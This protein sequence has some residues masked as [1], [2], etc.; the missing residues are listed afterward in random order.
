[1]HDGL[2]LIGTR[3]EA[4]KMA[5]LVQSLFRR[6]LRPYLVST[7]QHE[8]RLLAD[9]LAP[10]DCSIDAELSAPRDGDSLAAR[11]AHLL[12]EC[13]AVTQGRP[14]V[15]VHGDTQTTWAGAYGAFLSGVPVV[16]VEAGLR[17]FDREQPF[18]EEVNR[19]AVS[20]VADLHLAPTALSAAHL[21]HERVDG[22]IVVTGQT[23]V[24][25]AFGLLG[26]ESKPVRRWSGGERRSRVV[27]TAHRR[28][29]WADGV[30][31]IAN[32]VKE[33]ARATAVEVMVVLHPN[34]VVADKIRR[35]L[36]DVAGVTLVRPMPYASFLPHLA[37][38]DLVIT[39]SG[40]LQEE[41]ASLGTPFLVCREVTERPEGIE[42]GCGL[43]VGTP[44][45]GELAGL[46]HA[47]LVDSARWEAMAQSP[48]PFGDGQAAQRCVDA[49][50]E[51]YG[52]RDNA[53]AA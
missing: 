48:N 27:V 15:A 19:R 42:S 36:G 6:G 41:C 7:G 14:W 16:H 49:I 2:V 10:F 22:R 5:P 28:E 39:D 23:S 45:P 4:I 44:D 47:L 33:L 35:T 38:A 9:A 17:S 12:R 21:R 26:L 34:P 52:R 46:A 50:V 30:T 40:G 24:D 13:S 32:G 18:P 1:M 43:L 37:H 25:A 11:A 3:P 31:A 51:R 29:N 20:L 53:V 8:R